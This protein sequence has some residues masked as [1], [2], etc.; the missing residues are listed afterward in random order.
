MENIINN[1]G[2]KCIIYF[3]IGLPVVFIN[4]L[5]FSAEKILGHKITINSRE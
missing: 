5:Q 4:I 2:K 1:T 3:I